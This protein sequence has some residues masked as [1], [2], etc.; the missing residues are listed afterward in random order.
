MKENFSLLQNFS[1]TTSDDGRKLIQGFANQNFSLKTNDDGSKSIE[2]FAIHGGEDFIVKGFFEIPESEIKNCVKTLK[3]AKLLKDHDTGHVDSIIGRVNTA[4][5]TYD[6]LAD[7]QGAYYQA[8]LVVDDTKLAEKIDKGLIDATSIGFTFEPIC[9]I[10]GNP[11]FSEECSH[12]VWFDDLH[13]LCKDMNVHELSLVTFGAD[14]YATVGGSLSA[15]AIHE[16]KEKFAKQ[17]ESFIMSNKDDTVE[18]LKSENLKLSQEVSDLK[19]QLEQQ[20]T[21][22]DKEKDALETSHQ[23]EVL[24]LQQ[25]KK[26]VDKQIAEMQEELS[27]FR[28]EAEAREAE[29]LQAKK[30][31]M[32]A[33][34]KELDFEDQI[35]EERLSDE[36]Y[37]DDKL[38][39]L[40]KV[41][42]KLTKDVVPKP[43]NPDQHY[44]GKAGEEGEEHVMFSGLINGFN[45]SKKRQAQ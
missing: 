12:D 45:V 31:E 44:E 43:N 13:F 38:A 1:V 30:D 37:I 41:E 34:A 25:E 5:K 40:Q 35:N 14:P 36:E 29:K 19:A 24:T 16:F 11:Y 39:M 42:S 21:D 7:M 17:K 9:S 2:G 20:K 6:E 27:A 4:K 28:A 8:S 22:F 32:L 33:L 23:E 26:A 18:T 10:C 15:K 3:G